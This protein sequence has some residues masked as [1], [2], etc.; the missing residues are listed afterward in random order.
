[1]LR[2]P[3]PDRQE[4]GR[5]LAGLLERYRDQSNVIV[6]ALP[7]GGVPV[8][9]VV[10]AHLHVPL[11]VFLVRKLGVPGQ[12]ELAF[13]AIGSGGVRV[14]NHELIEEV[15]LSPGPDRANLG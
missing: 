5:E 3:F 1:M 15:Q 10:A 7:R 14:L 6:L 13:G 8:A 12:E 2:L 9:G 4:A 11:D